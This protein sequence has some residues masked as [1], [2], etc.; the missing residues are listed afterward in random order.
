LQ[1][2][3]DSEEAKDFEAFVQLG[4][5]SKAQRVALIMR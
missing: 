1:Q 4:G 2:R 5:S 3:E